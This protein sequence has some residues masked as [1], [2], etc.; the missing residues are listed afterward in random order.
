[1]DTH[2]QNSTV[3]ETH[4]QNDCRDG[5]QPYGP[6][7]KIGSEEIGPCHGAGP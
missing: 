6:D 7:P 3:K 1:M 5:N 2:I 4:V